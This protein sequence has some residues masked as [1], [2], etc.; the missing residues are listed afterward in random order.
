MSTEKETDK[1]F[2][3]KIKKAEKTAYRAIYV[4]ALAT[5]LLTYSIYDPTFSIFKNDTK[6]LAY[7]AIEGDE[8]KIEKGIHV[9]TGLVDA[10]GLMTVVN[11]CT[12]CHSAKLVTQNRMN[13]ERWNA[14]IEWMQ[15]TQGLWNLGG[16]QEIIV[17]YLVKNYPV[18]DKG[19]R[20]NLTNIEWYELEN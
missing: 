1:R 9:R 8:D 7:N 13:K 12:N 20:E 16:N 11:N 18:I 4:L 6:N 19:R 14:T 5:T 15:D 3:E 2:Q 10:D 17:N